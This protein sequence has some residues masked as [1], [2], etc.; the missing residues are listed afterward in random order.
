MINNLKTLLLKLDAYG[1]GFTAASTTA[2]V[3]TSPTT[4]TLAKLTILC[5]SFALIIYLAL[6]NPWGVTPDYAPYIA[7]FDWARQASWSQVFPNSHSWEPGFMLLVF[8]LAKAIAANGW[9]FLSIVLFASS[10]KLGLL[11]A[12]SSPIA[13]LLAMVLFFFKYFPLQDYNQ[14]R[15]AIAISFLMLVYY[16]WVW[17]DNLRLALLFSVCAVS[18][19][20]LVLG[21]LPFAFLVKHNEFLKKSRLLLFFFLGLAL[22]LGAGYVLLEYLAPLIPRLSFQTYLAP[23]TASYLSPIFYPE[24]FLLAVSF[25]FWNECTQNM[26][27]VVAIQMVGFAIFYG[28]F[29]FEVVAIRLR[30]A[31]AIFWLFYVADYS[32]T[33]PR[34]RLATVVFVLMNIALGSYVFYF[35]TYLK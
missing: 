5:L 21:I 3:S 30:E 15:G 24:V 7:S 4:T 29:N 19:H 35:S 11:Y 17:K 2:T 13:F 18:F 26:R 32:R 9:V 14:L 22:L 27:R 10:F 33:T 28:F 1:H 16:Q 8:L 12:I 31:F 20:Y 34:L 25:M 6:F 23:A